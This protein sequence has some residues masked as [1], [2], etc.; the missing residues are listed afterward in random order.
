M[1][2]GGGVSNV[3]SQVGVGRQVGVG[4]M[5][6]VGRGS[7]VGQPGHLSYNDVAVATITPGPSGGGV[8][9]AN[10]N[11]TSR[12]MTTDKAATTTRE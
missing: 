12:P 11:D 5:I 1:Y 6:Y 7:Q 4:G 2:V 8:A 3:G 10:V 9:E